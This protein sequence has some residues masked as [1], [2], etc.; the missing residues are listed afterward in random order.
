MAGI[1]AGAVS[2]DILANLEKLASDVREGAKAAAAAATA[3]VAVKAD[4]EKATGAIKSDTAKAAAAASE[5]ARISAKGDAKKAGTQITAD[6]KTAVSEAS[7]ETIRPKADAA[8]VGKEVTGKTKEAVAEGSRQVVRPKGD[9]DSAGKSIAAGLKSHLGAITGVIS[10]AL[11][12]G[13]IVKFGRDAVNSFESAAGA[14]IGL[15]RNLGVTT[16]D[17]SRLGYAAKQSNVNTDAFANSMKIMEKNIGGAAGATSGATKVLQG[18][19]VQTRDAAGNMRP[20]TDL[21]PDIAAKFK[22]MPDGADKTAAAMKI[23]GRSGADMVPMLN[24]GSD[25]I[26]DLMAQSDKFGNTIGKDQATAFA[27]SKASQ[28]EWNASLEGLKV[29][30]GSQILPIL[31]AATNMIR[32]K[33]IPA[34]VDVTKF[35]TQHKTEISSTAKVL[36]PIISVITGV[37]GALVMI[38]KV[39][40]GVK[41]TA[42]AVKLLG[43]SFKSMSTVGL[44][45]RVIGLIIA[46]LA[47]LYATS[48]KFRA[49]VNGI[50]TAIKNTF[51]A[52]IGWFTGSLVPGFKKVWGTI[53]DVFKTAGRAL[54]TAFKA[55]G[56]V[57]SSIAKGIGKVMNWLWK[58]V[59]QP[60]WNG[61]KVA[62]SVVVTII[63]LELRG[64]IL[65]FQKVVAPVF[66]W[67]WQHIVKP[68]FEGISNAI[69]SVVDWFKN[70]V[71]PVFK[72]VGKAIG[73]SFT[74]L[75][76][77][78]G[79]AW[80]W[81]KDHIIEPVVK[82]FE[83]NVVDRTKAFIKLEIDGF[84]NL[85]D[86]IG[87]A[88]NWIKD[89]IIEPV[90]KWFET[91]VI[92]RFKQAIQNAKDNFANFRD[93][94]SDIW[95]WIKDHIIN[96]V[97]EWFER[98][99]VNR[100][101]QV[102][103][104]IVDAFN[105]VKDGVGKAWDAMKELAAKPIRFVVNT[106]VAGLVGKY[107]DIAGMFGA[108]KADVPHV[109]FATGG[110]LPGYTPG[111]DVHAFV[112]PATGMLLNLSGG[113]AVMRP[114]FTAAV[115]PEW[116]A[117]M[118]ALAKSG[119][120]GGLRSALGFADG[121]VMSFAGGGVIGAI[122]GVA[123]GIGDF[124]KDPIGSLKKVVQGF[125]DKINSNPFGRLITR[126]PGKIISTIGDWVKEHLG[127]LFGGNTSKAAQ[128][129]A[130]QITAA[131]QMLGIASTPEH[132]QAWVRQIQ[133]ESGGNPN[134]IQ[135]NIGDVNNASGDLAKGLVQVIG[136][137]FSAYHVPGFDNVFDG[138]SNILAGMNYA[139]SRYGGEGMF[140]VI[141]Q[142]HGYAGG[143][144]LPR[145]YDAG[146]WLPTGTSVVRNETGRPERIL[147]PSEGTGG[148]DLRQMATV[149]RQVLE[150]MGLVFSV[151]GQHQ[152]EAVVDGRITRSAVGARGLR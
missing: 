26:K 151:D 15:S 149:F 71:A 27:K 46:A 130:P 99:V 44:I 142:G 93:N 23:F 41:A 65:V 111:R 137:T 138:M 19:G 43:N 88:W 134:A 119:G 97:V 83:T 96:P 63:S 110:V 82:W 70:S 38:G 33:V 21:L 91:N 95:N 152:F 80:N 67:L 101:V 25:G 47:S 59:I 13:A 136:A 150:G 11:A 145:L 60:V 8:G 109:D 29:S 89:H 124:L 117:R 85:R 104:S 10:G 45:V 39:A 50:G 14:A 123:S 92:A 132:V 53:S 66:T 12:S 56:D 36:V 87:D 42:G 61:I 37:G 102:K 94:L 24:K 108:P 120:V 31:T 103:N 115:G 6:T 107:N 22:T 114:E 148:T 144:V 57:F 16:D 76:D 81:I 64:W 74:G 32:Q 129:W 113:E 28:K 105:A 84:N 34:V 73:D 127:G 49:F 62:I 118:N 7:R 5:S 54:G 86:R 52:V 125:E 2:V 4:T 78:V 58:S 48:P 1:S 40:S 146:G 112:D 133:T 139:K 143:G 75:R 55:V 30:I 69:K 140:G 18:L 3:T 131:L 72:S 35:V 121:G 68:A 126:V 20:M 135:G 77:A 106:V 79:N 147:G 17:A 98:D 100:F 128:D 9:G 90:V 116:V 51:G 141:G 122:K